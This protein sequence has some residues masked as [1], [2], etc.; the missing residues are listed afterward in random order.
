MAVGGHSSRA[1]D[2]NVRV[3]LGSHV[4]RRVRPGTH[5]DTRRLHVPGAAHRG[6]GQRPG[7]PVPLARAR[8][9]LA[10]P[11]DS[12]SGPG[13][14]G[15]HGAQQPVRPVQPDRG[16]L[17]RDVQPLGDLGVRAL[18]DIPGP[19]DR[20][21]R[22]PRGSSA[23]RHPGPP[24]PRLAAGDRPGSAPKGA[25]RRPPRA[26]EA[27]ASEVLHPRNARLGRAAPGRPRRSAGR[28]RRA[29]R[30]AWAPGLRR[31]RRG[32]RARL[33][34]ARSRPGTAV[35]GPGVEPDAQPARRGHSAVGR[36]VDV[37]RPTSPA[38][39]PFTPPPDGTAAP[40]R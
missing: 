34:T 31:R 17:L 38:Q 21:W 30:A 33:G 9:T 35:A 40:W 1:P 13:R 39:N 16:V 11:T 20:D 37:P 28:R 32:R 29:R 6:P 10:P 5:D 26:I 24:R 7:V 36:R 25:V 2:R 23:P 22:R 15:Q 12:F 4:V 8:H 18:L 27:G 3:R 14:F 19:R